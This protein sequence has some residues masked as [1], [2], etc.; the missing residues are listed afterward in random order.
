MDYI[1]EFLIDLEYVR[2]YS[3]NTIA[4]YNSD[5]TIFSN[6]LNN[7]DL[8]K[9]MTDDIKKFI[10]YLSDKKDKTLARYMTTFRMF[11]DFMLKKKYISVNPM[12]GI[13]SPKIGKYLP[14]VLSIDEVNRLLDFNPKNN[15]EFRDRCILEMLYSTGLRI[16]ELVN[17]KLEN[18]NI[19]ESFVKVMGKGSKER[20]VPFNDITTEYLDKYIREVRPK[21]L[22]KVQ[23]DYLFLNNHGKNLSRQAVFK[24]IKKRAGEAN[25]DKN[26]SPHTLRH[27]FATHLLLGG[28]DIRFIQELLGHSDVST[29]EIYTHIA[30]STLKN[31]YNDLNPRDN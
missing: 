10:R 2:N 17:L 21:M 18:V 16:S 31:D 8:S 9:V 11:Y 26:I 27:T 4:S 30:S 25:I 12:D 19:E 6:F 22:K 23:S 24:M 20:I 5:L 29:T 3:K 15:F 1:N 14:E 28:A 7:K 13:S